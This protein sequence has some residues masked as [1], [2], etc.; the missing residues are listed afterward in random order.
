[1]SPSEVFQHVIRLDLPTLHDQPRWWFRYERE[2]DQKQSGHHGTQYRDDVQTIG[3]SCK[4][5]AY[6]YQFNK[7]IVQL[8]CTRDFNFT[9]E[10]IIMNEI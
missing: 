2:E 7:V 1:M 6:A 5:C 4:H 8:G 10:P 9:I 3:E